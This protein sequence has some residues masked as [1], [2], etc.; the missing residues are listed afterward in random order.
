VGVGLGV[1]LM[2]MRR[3]VE[4][5]YY[6]RDLKLNVQL[7]MLYGEAAAEVKS[8]SNEDPSKPSDF[9][10]LLVPSFR[11]TS[12]H[13]SEMIRMHIMFYIHNKR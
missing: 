7:G 11:T 12:N 4:L 8:I 2:V 6:V 10:S 9:T 3:I 13:A 1:V 5:R